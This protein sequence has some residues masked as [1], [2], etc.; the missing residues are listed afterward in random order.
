MDAKPER[1]LLLTPQLEDIGGV[2]NYYK[3]LQLHRD[4]DR[5]DYLAVTGTGHESILQF[6]ARL[7]RNY[8][9]FWNLLGTG[10]YGLVI[11]N[12][13][14]DPRAFYRDAVFCWLAQIRGVRVLVFFRGWVPAFEDRIR[15]SFLPKFVFRRTMARVRH[16]VVLGRVFERK[17]VALGAAAD[18]RFWIE[19]TVADATHLDRF[20]VGFRQD[21]ANSLK[22]LFLARLTPAKRPFL[23]LEAFN[24][25][26]QRRPDLNLELVIAGPGPEFPHLQ[27][28]IEADGIRNVTLAGPVRDIAKAELLASAHVL[29]HPTASGEGMPNAILEAMLYGM[30]VLSTT[31][32]A[33]PEILEHGINGYIASTPDPGLFADWIIQLATNIELRSRISRT[34]RDKAL[35]LY[36]VD[37]VRSRLRSVIDECLVR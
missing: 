12:P 14:L 2:G 32:G 4:D 36:T 37:K 18:S 3:A 20:P 23:A 28:R 21:V 27:R 26:Q 35:R 8:W 9:R 11:L 25:A 7:T 31:M 19:T 30:P 22:L 34:N 29:L 33:I 6:S 5:I 24:L 13:S 15:D 16:F 1:V 10:K 17:V